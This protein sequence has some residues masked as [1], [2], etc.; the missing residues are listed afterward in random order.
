[1]LMFSCTTRDSSV[2]IIKIFFLIYV[3]F[4]RFLL[5]DVVYHGT[6]HGKDGKAHGRL[7]KR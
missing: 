1:M 7:Q 4:Y 3:L 5:I 2:A 6:M